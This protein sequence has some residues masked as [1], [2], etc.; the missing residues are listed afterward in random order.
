MTLGRLQLYL[1]PRFFSSSNDA[2]FNRSL[3][4]MFMDAIRRYRSHEDALRFRQR[5]DPTAW[6]VGRAFGS[7]ASGWPDP[8]DSRL[9][10]PRCSLLFN[11][12]WQNSPRQT[13]AYCEWIAIFFLEIFLVYMILSVCLLP[14]CCFG[15]TQAK[16]IPVRS[17]IHLPPE[18]L[19]TS[20]F[21]LFSFLQPDEDVLTFNVMLAYLFSLSTKEDPVI[22]VHCHY[23]MFWKMYFW[24][25][26]SQWGFCLFAG[27]NRT[28][29]MVCW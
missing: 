7:T 6:R 4:F 28:G 21:E 5:A 17:R 19:P 24:R 27:Y 2:G 8:R 26:I 23:G 11:S 9:D 20:N 22:A 1:R 16:T 12:Q 18:S 29:Y 13:S 14:W 15:F 25:V 3:P 10:G